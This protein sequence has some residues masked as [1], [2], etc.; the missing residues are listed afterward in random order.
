MPVL[1]MHHPVLD[2]CTF[3]DRAAGRLV[4]D[5]YPVISDDELEE[6]EARYVVSAMLARDVGFD[7]ID[8]KQCHTYLLNELLAARNRRGRYGGSFENRTRFIRNVLTRIRESVGDSILLASR[9]NVYDGVPYRRRED[10]GVGEAAAC[11]VPYDGGFGVD[12]EYP[13]RAE[14]TEPMELVALLRAHGVALVNVSMG[15]PY[16][17]PHIGRPYDR[18]NEGSYI[19]PEHPLIGVER[20]FRLTAALQERFPDLALVG[21]GYS[22]L[23]RYFINA[24]ESNLQRKRVTVVAVGRGAIAY[25]EFA[26]DA[27]RD[28]LLDRKRVCLAVSFC[29]DLMRS[30]SDP[31]GQTPSGCVPRDEVYAD[32]FK[33]IHSMNQKE[34]QS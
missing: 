32:I 10:D 34:E 6:L 29:T 24:A 16:F 14:L 22:W 20:H 1:A 11:P 13:L 7:F 30:K 25:P 12:R 26:R 17:N 18:P 27:L 19:A 31:T 8:L 5:A 28:G 9:I 3:V 4:T 33:S 15:S 2:R 23:Q 21:T